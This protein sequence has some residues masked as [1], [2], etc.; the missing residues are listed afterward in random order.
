M[1]IYIFNWPTLRDYLIKSYATDK[2]LEDFGKNVIPAYLAHN[3]SVYAYAFQGYW[4]DVGTIQS[5]WQ[6]NMEFLS[7]HN[8]LNIG[9][10][11]W[12]IYS[13]TEVLPPM[14]LTKTRQ[15]SDAMI[16][17][18]CYVAGEID[19]SILSQRV[20]VGMG[21]RGVDSMVMPGATIG[22]NAVIDHALIGEN[23]V[24][25]DDAQ[26]KGRTD[27]IAV[28]GYNEVVGVPQP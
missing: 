27:N 16:V 23:A 28:V 1:G 8:Q 26:V 20:S 6:A 19:H 10:E 18:S 14:F 9:D 21:S 24:I 3:E 15:V 5:L 22:K 11:Q 4:R 2:S 13:K 25:G 7:P 12:R 17:D